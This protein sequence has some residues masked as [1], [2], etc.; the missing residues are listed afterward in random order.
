[1]Y[2]FVSELSRLKIKSDADFQKQT[3]PK[4]VDNSWRSLNSNRFLLHFIVQWT[5]FTFLTVHCQLY[6][7]GYGS[8][9]RPCTHC[10][11][12]HDDRA[13]LDE[14]VFTI[15]I[16]AWM[17]SGCGP[18]NGNGLLLFSYMYMCTTQQLRFSQ[19]C[20]VWKTQKS[21]HITVLS[22]HF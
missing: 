21:C 19:S 20:S 3:P 12:C 18:G 22:V 6:N 8:F 17:Q 15:M 16:R 5:T 7:T 11:H 1:M 10:C 9:D 14:Q 13:C 4:H 2:I